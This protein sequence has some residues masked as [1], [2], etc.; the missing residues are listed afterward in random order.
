MEFPFENYSLDTMPAVVLDKIFNYLT[1][2]DVFEVSNTNHFMQE[3]CAKPKYWKKL[4]L[5]VSKILLAGNHCEDLTKKFAEYWVQS[6]NLLSK[7]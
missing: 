5:N 2:E 3:F 1:P 6:S 4:V 7:R